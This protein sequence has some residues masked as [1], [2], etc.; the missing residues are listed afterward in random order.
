MPYPV[1]YL[2]DPRPQLA[3]EVGGLGRVSGAEPHLRPPHEPDRPPAPLPLGLDGS[4][5][6]ARVTPFPRRDAALK[7]TAGRAKGVPSCLGMPPQLPARFTQVLERLRAEDRGLTGPR[8]PPVA[9]WGSPLPRMPP[10][11]PLAASEE[12]LGAQTASPPAACRT[13]PSSRACREAPASRASPWGVGA[14]PRPRTP[15]PPPTGGVSAPL[16]DVEKL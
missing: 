16:G 3:G 8:R 7:P 13:I 4:G 9:R 14:S 15:N 12:P 1:P 6:A 2:A 10:P 5:P 11:P